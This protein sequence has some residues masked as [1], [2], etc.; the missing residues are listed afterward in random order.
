MTTG[1]IYQQIIEK[2]RAGFY[3]GATIQIIPHVTDAIKEQIYQPK[4]DIVIVEIGGTVGDIESLPFL[5]AIRQIRREKGKE[6][7]CFVHVTLLPYLEVSGEIKTKP[8]QHSVKEL[9][10]LGIQPDIIVLRTNQIVDDGIKNKISSFCD[11]ERDCVFVTNDVSNIYYVPNNLL[12]QNLDKRVLSLLNIKDTIIDFSVWNNLLDVLNARKHKIRI[13]LVG[14]YITLHDSYLS[15]VEALK[16]AGYP[17]SSKIHI[18]W[19]SSEVLNDATAHEYL[20][21]KDGIIVPGGF[22]PRGMEGMISA[23]KYAR[24][25]KV[26]LFGICLGM[27]MIS[28]ELARNVLGI[29]DATTLEI[30]KN[31]IHPVVTYLYN[32]KMHIGEHEVQLIPNTIA[33]ASYKE[34]VI[35][36]RFRHRFGLNPEYVGLYKKAG[37]IISGTSNEGLIP[38]IIEIKDH[39]FFVGIQAHPEFK[40]RPTNC[41]PLFYSFIEAAF[42]KY[43]SRPKSE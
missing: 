14:K 37:I 25:N 29:T 27:Q 21:D 40:S 19:I 5:D 24:I 32:K 41:H 2:E 20:A 13:A 26:P 28:I 38:E 1:K 7:V 35:H 31:A 33:Y 18:D 43:L 23:I 12:L 17:F 9:R 10:S 4:E 11:V 3:N 16:H 39:P 34:K 15:V 22:G 36:E 6:N 8:T 30:D 42:K